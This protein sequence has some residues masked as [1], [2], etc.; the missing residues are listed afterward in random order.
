MGAFCPETLSQL[1]FLE[2]AWEAQLP[3]LR[4]QEFMGG[5]QRGTAKFPKM[6]FVLEKT[7]EKFNR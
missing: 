4:I 1:A 6:R 5:E 3:H 7:S 2:Y